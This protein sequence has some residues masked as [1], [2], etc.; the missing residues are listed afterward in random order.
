MLRDASG[1]RGDDLTL[2]Q[3]VQQRGL[4]VVHV[5]HDGDH[6]GAGRQLGRV[7][8]GSGGGRGQGSEVRDSG[9]TDQQRTRVTLNLSL[10]PI[11][12]YRA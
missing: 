10:T 4:P 3:A 5:A 12:P 2:P 8:R 9:N 1:L 7:R 6:G 11:G